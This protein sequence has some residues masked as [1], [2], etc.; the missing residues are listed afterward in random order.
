MLSHYQSG[1]RPIVGCGTP[2]SNT[3]HKAL[4]LWHE[5]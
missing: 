1:V 2:P 3:C 4:K 5:Q